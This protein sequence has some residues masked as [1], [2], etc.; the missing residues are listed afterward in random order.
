MKQQFL[1]FLAVPSNFRCVLVEIAFKNDAGIDDIAYLSNAAFITSP[2]DLPANTSYD[3][4]IVAGLEITRAMSEVFTGRSSSYLSDLEIVLNPFTE[5]LAH[6]DNGQ[7]AVYMGAKEWP[8]ADFEQVFVGE[9]ENAAPGKDTITIEFK[10]KA[11]T[12]DKP[13]LNAVYTNGPSEGLLK[14]LLLGQCFNVSPVLIDDANHIYQFNSVASINVG[15]VR[16]NGDTV[17]SANYVIDL[18]ASTI[19]FNVKPQ[20]TITIDAAGPHATAAQMISYFVPGAIVTG[21]PTYTLGLFIADELTISDALDLVCKSVGAY[22]YFDRKGQF[23]CNAFRGV[24]NEPTSTLYDDLNIA[25]SR[26]PRR[27]IKALQQLSLEYAINYTPLSA[28]SAVVFDTAPALAQQLTKE[29][30]SVVDTNAVLGDTLKARTLIANKA[31]A[32]TEL[33]RRL[34]LKTIPRFIYETEQLA[35]PFSWLLGDTLAL[36]S[37]AKNGERAIL[38]RLSEQ[39]LT[40]VCTVEFYQ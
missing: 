20:G 34:A 5:K 13:C 4:V 35:A 1:D 38:T 31:D 7:I 36:E 18:A 22:W 40:G 8:K 25:Y 30:S 33:A 6:I 9:I 14:P 16:F 10:D 2:T 15:N 26:Q 28:V 39:L 12:L 24:T 19:K 21:L 37:S 32:Q 29:A 23:I 27:K 3:D 11:K 17:S